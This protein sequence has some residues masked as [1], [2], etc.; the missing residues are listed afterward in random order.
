MLVLSDVDPDY[1]H[2]ALLRWIDDLIG[3]LA[4]LRRTSADPLSPVT[5]GG[6]QSPFTDGGRG[7][8][9]R[10]NG[11]AR[12][13]GRRSPRHVSSSLTDPTRGISAGSSGS[14]TRPVPP[15]RHLG[16]MTSRSRTAP[17]V[18]REVMPGM[19]W[20]GRGQAS[21][22][23]QKTR[24]SNCRGAVWLCWCGSRSRSWHDTGPKSETSQGTALT[25]QTKAP[26]FVIDYHLVDLTLFG[27][28]QSRAAST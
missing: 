6:S 24:R 1:A 16:P 27:D 26:T 20:R 3:V 10:R 4:A 13:A 12:I 19:V 25:F 2:A 23:S 5:A 21:A 8:V 11:L 14:I 17:N 22:S 7:P 18:H 28:P 9:T 15:D